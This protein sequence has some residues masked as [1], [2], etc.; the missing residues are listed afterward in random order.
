MIGKIHAAATWNPVVVWRKIR[1]R[2][3]VGCALVNA[4]IVAGLAVYWFLLPGAILLRDLSDIRLRRPLGI[5]RAVWRLHRALTPR[6]ERWARQRIASGVAAH[7]DLYDVPSTEWPMFG[8]VFYLSATEALQEEW[9]RDPSVAPQAPRDYA[10]QAI[11]ACT[12]LVLDPVHHTWVRQHWGS[13]YFHRENVFFR[14][15]IIQA[16]TSRE[17]L[18][19]DGKH[20]DLLRDQVETLAAELDQSPYGLLHDYPGECYPV[21][22]FAAIAWIRRADAVLGTDH[23]AFVQRALRAFSAPYLDERG[24]VPYSVDLTSGTPDSPSRGIGMSYV[25]IYAA[26]LYPEQARRWYDLYVQ[27]FWQDNWLASGFREYPKDMAHTDWLMDPDSGPVMFGFSP[28]GNAYGVAAARVNGRFDHAWTLGAQALA[29]AWPLPNGR[30]LGAR[31]LSA[32]SRG[33]APYLG[34]M[35]LLFLFTRQ[36]AP[37][38]PIVTGGHLPL[39]VWIGFGLTL[40]LGLFLLWATLRHCQAWLRDADTALVPVER[41]Q[42]TLWIVLIGLS[43]VFLLAGDMKTSVI[44]LLLAQ[45]LPRQSARSQLLE[46]R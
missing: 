4:L 12:D 39:L 41:I 43:G 14:A 22:V 9:D 7:L 38:V 36:P 37:G 16:L 21:D 29:A 5:P 30:W 42:L 33:H 1:Q 20:L 45:F 11:D 6:Y 46:Q 8:S 40:G 26:E 34:E 18:L 32:A 23:R 35:N 24:L 15:M 28:S 17:H 19:H 31:L 25:L 10:R 44:F 27:N 2:P 13:D 3:L